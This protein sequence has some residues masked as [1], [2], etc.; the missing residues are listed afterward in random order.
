MQ[1][2]GQ[3]PFAIPG[4][5]DSPEMIVEKA[6]RIY[7]A[8]NEYY[9]AMGVKHPESYLGGE[10]ETFEEAIRVVAVINPQVAM[11]LMEQYQMQMAQYQMQMAQAQAAAN[12][13]GVGAAPGAGAYPGAAGAGGAGGIPGVP[14][15]GAPAGMGAFVPRLGPA[16]YGSS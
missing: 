5:M 14:G 13:M 8:Y 3:N 15:L 1:S 12:P 9:Q 7:K 10:P 6:K 16:G 2:M 4:I 11:Q